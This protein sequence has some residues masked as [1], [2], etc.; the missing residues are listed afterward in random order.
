MALG[1]LAMQ[2]EAV[3]ADVDTEKRYR[4]HERSSGRKTRKALQA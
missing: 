1:V 2:V 3:F 4:I